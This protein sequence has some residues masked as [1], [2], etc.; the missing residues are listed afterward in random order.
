MKASIIC[1]KQHFCYSQ[2]SCYYSPHLFVGTSYDSSHH[3][4]HDRRISPK[5]VL[6]C[7]SAKL[8]HP[9]GL[10][11]VAIC[12]T[13]SSQ[14]TSR[15]SSSSQ[16]PVSG[17][18]SSATRV[19]TVW[20]LGVIGLLVISFIIHGSSQ[21]LICI[22]SPIRQISPFCNAWSP[23]TM[24]RQVYHTSPSIAAHIMNQDFA[25]SSNP[26]VLTSPN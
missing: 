17:C 24:L 16:L 4:K 2:H 13:S 10:V 19:K 18:S 8:K 20:P 3:P 22:P 25:E 9:H 21:I 12:R 14:N 6:C 5:I 7:Q 26:T 11:G 23:R 1:A 15:T